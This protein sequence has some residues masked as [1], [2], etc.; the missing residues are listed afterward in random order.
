MDNYFNTYINRDMRSLLPRID[1]IKYQRVIKMLSSVSGTII[2]KSE[3]ARSAETSEKSI[4]DYLQIISGT[5]FW[6][7]LPA[8]KTP[9]IKTTSALPKGHFRDSGLLLFLQNI[10]NVEDLEFYPKLGNAF[11]SFAVEEVIRGVQAVR[12]RNVNAYHFR[13]KAGGKIDLV[14][15]GSFGLLPIEIKYQSNTTKKQLTSMSNFIEMHKLPY[16]LVINNCEAPSMITEN[17][18][19]LPAGCI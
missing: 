4:R 2:N 8:F 15:E 10:F 9:K 13:T 16:G 7:E 19:Q 1:I 17:I 11:E 12:S 5:F 6:R 14:M 3:L 18:L